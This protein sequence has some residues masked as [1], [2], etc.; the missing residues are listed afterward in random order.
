MFEHDCFVK[1]IYVILQKHRKGRI[2]RCFFHTIEPCKAGRR[3]FDILR[4]VKKVYV[5]ISNEIFNAFTLFFFNLATYFVLHNNDESAEVVM[6][7]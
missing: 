5:I 2:F 4:Y 3:R 7:K 1:Q 6:L